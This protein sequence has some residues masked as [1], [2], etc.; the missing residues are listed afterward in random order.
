MAPPRRT[1]PNYMDVDSDSDISLLGDD[2]VRARGKGKSKATD[3]RKKDKG[4]GKA[5]D[6]RPFSCSLQ[7]LPFEL[8]T[9]QAYTWEASYARSWDTVQEDES[10]SL[11]GAVEDLM[12]RSR[13]R[14]HAHRL[15]HVS[16]SRSSS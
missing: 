5:K 11:Q 15:S 14:R 1:D 10:G 6:V 12:A 16:R 9:Q 13:R 3:K 4:K 8:S 2:E 7:L